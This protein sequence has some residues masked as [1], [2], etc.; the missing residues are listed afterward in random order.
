MHRD[1]KWISGCLRL[2]EQRGLTVNGPR[3]SFE[4]DGKI[5]RLDYSEG[6]T[7]QV[8]LLKVIGLFSLNG[9]IL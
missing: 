6:G 9:L 7:R 4:S 8:N 2:V 1:R 3:G 5:L